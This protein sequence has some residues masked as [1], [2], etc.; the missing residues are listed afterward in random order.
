MG[1]PELPV[2]HTDPARGRLAAELRRLRAAARL[3]YD[4]LAAATGVSAATLKRA[5]SGRSVPSWETVQAIVNVCGG[6]NGAVERLWQRARISKR[7]RLKKLRQPGAPALVMTAGQLGEALAYFYEEAGALPLRRLQA[8]AGGSHQLPVSTAA[9]IVRQQALPAS[10]QQCI[11]FLTACGIGPRLAQRWADAYDQITDPRLR[12]LSDA[13]AALA[14]MTRQLPRR[15][16]LK[17]IRL[18]DLRHGPGRDALER[19]R[20]FVEGPFTELER[21]PRYLDERHHPPLR[22]PRAA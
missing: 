4:E 6:P 1:R 21:D 15:T 8:L 18:R 19:G 13:E 7:D 16:G 11:A 10:R 3:T 17:D 22:R 14:I 2:D 20:A 5:A 12:R 9:R